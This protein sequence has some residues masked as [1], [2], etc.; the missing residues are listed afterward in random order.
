MMALFKADRFRGKN[1]LFLYMKTF[2][3]LEEQ[4]TFGGLSEIHLTFGCLH[5]ELEASLYDK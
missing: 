5:R 3:C 4:L 2:N 1:L